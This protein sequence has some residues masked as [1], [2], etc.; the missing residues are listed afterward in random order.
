MVRELIPLNL[1]RLL[2]NPVMFRMALLFV[3]A[4]FALVVAILFIWVLRRR[5]VAKDRRDDQRVSVD[6]SAFTIAAYDGVIRKLK[7]QEQELQRL[8]REDR[9]RAIE[10]AS[11][12][13]AVLS[14]LDSGVLLFSNTMTVRQANP[15]A[16]TLLGYASP[17]SLHARDI[18]RGVSA[19]RVGTNSAPANS[20]PATG[21][22][23]DWS[24]AGPGPL[25]AALQSCMKSGASYKRLQVEYKPPDDTNRVLG[26]TLSPVLGGAGEC[27]GAISLI[28]DLTEI[29]HLS[30]PDRRD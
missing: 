20:G 4:V 8:R 16:K 2:Q 22:E 21:D 6:H 10:S 14:N 26:I 17:F 9:D 11:I 7:E 30:R 13:H 24:A 19:V 15:A 3:F 28:S 18:F 25:V 5:L 1:T 12:S 27:L 29:I 23:I